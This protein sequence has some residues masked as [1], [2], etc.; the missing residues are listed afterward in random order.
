MKSEG[1]GHS[2]VQAPCEANNRGWENHQVF[3]LLEIIF[4]LLIMQLDF[5]ESYSLFL[6]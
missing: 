3:T 1:L 2:M 6:L 5:L 4:N